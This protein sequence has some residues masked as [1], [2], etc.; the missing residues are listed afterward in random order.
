MSPQRHTDPAAL[1]SDS[2]FPGRTLLA[3]SVSIWLVAAVL[4]LVFLH[5]KTPPPWLQNAQAGLLL[6]T[7]P[8]Y[9]AGFWLAVRG[10]GY[11]RILSLIALV[12]PIGL[13]IIF[14]LPTL[15]GPDRDN[16]VIDLD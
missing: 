6:V 5:L 4:P 14:F 10:K 12:P 13:M 9:L 8:F 7:L 15:E 1:Y 3:T 11:A 16:P 2:H